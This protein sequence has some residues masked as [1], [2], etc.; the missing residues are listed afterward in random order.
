MTA[1]PDSPFPPPEPGLD[2]AVRA[3]LDA[4]AART[5]TP[6]VW[7]GV[8][9]R[10][11]ADAAP[12]P[13]APGKPTR[14][15][16]PGAVLA[17][18]ATAAAVLVAF[19]FWPSPKQVAASPSDALRQARAAH[20]G[21]GRAYSFAIDFPP[22]LKDRF[23]L[24]ADTGR[25]QT[26][27][28]SGD[29]FVV[30]PGFTGQ[31]AW[32]RDHLGRVWVAPSREAAARFTP[33]ELPP[34]LKDA[35]AVRGLELDTLLGELLADYD[36]TWAADDRIS[37]TPRGSVRPL[38]VLS[39]DIRLDQATPVIRQL[40]LRRLLVNDG[41]VTLTFRLTDPGSEVP[42]Y[43]VERHLDPNAPVH[44]AHTPVL[45]RRVLL[46]GLGELLANGL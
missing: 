39:A 30:S 37:A 34:V 6:A 18:A 29:N 20:A 23:P 14:R 46:Q 4:E 35:V 31:G 15:R 12:P 40:T 10:L 13:T 28:T 32:G 21:R 17:S 2:A 27:W 36:L 1:P 5:N 25:R 8:L 24:L 11:N 38:G 22:P 42:A 44:D 16:W 9:A 43:V 45:R 33:D 26:V 19:V 41:V 3:Q 7:E